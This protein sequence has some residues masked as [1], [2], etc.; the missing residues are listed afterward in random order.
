VKRAAP[1]IDTAGGGSGV[2][3]PDTLDRVLREITGVTRVLG[4]HDPGLPPGVTRSSLGDIYT[5]TDLQEY[6][7]FNRAFL[8]AVRG[9]MQQGK[10]SAEAAAALSLP[11]KF[12][13]Y[14]MK[15]AKNNVEAIYKELSGPGRSAR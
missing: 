12:A 13:G 10:S 9:A 3:F 7:E 14:D 4:G 8:E 15:Q 5:W 1:V 2:S 11:A 6:A